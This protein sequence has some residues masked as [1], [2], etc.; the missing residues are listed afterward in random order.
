MS[1]NATDSSAILRE[2]RK[3]PNGCANGWSGVP[4][5]AE[6]QRWKGKAALKINEIVGLVK[7]Y[8]L[9]AYIVFWRESATLFLSVG[10]FNAKLIFLHIFTDVFRR[11]C[12]HKYRLDIL[13]FPLVIST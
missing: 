5:S 12:I 9:R 10:K 2:E 11:S 6:K 7:Y 13:F 1:P 3:I 8:A 4:D